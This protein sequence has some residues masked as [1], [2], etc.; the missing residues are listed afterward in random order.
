MPVVA[1]LALAATMAAAGFAVAAP[2]TNGAELARVI[3]TRQSGAPVNCIDPRHQTSVQVIEGTAI[4]Y[5]YGSRLYVNR[6]VQGAEA[7]RRT[8][9]LVASSFRE[10]LCR[11]DTVTLLDPPSRFP[12]GVVTLGSFVPY[13]KPPR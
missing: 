1:I 11:L 9:V 6:P 3:G 2:A 13:S 12:R 7:L 8:D 10:Q 4:V 5:E